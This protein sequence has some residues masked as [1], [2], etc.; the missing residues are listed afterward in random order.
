MWDQYK[1]SFVGMQTVI[2]VVAALVFAWS[3]FWAHAVAFFVMMQAGSALG[4]LW[5]HRLKRKLP[6]P[7]CGTFVPKT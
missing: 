5:G 2:F 1:K 3:H 7:A 6:A 4:A